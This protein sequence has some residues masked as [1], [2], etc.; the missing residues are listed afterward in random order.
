[1]EGR[2][3]YFCSIA[4][5]KN[6]FLSLDL[7]GTSVILDKFNII[8]KTPTY[9]VYSDNGVIGTRPLIVSGFVEQKGGHV[10]RRYGR[11]DHQ[12]QD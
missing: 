6:V 4:L 10:R 9:Q 3:G 12:K 11:V 8:K 5:V 2:T 1:M 7:F